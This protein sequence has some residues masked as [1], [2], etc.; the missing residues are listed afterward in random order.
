MQAKVLLCDYA[1]VAQNKL[2]ITG[3]NI[4]RLGVQPSEPPYG[5]NIALA[6]SVTIPWNATNQQHV[7][8]IELVSDQGGGTS[9]RVPLSGMLPPNHDPADNGMIVAA[10]NAGRAPDMTPGEDTLIP[11]AIPIFGLPLPHPGSYFFNIR[12]DG[13]DVDRVSFRVD[14]MNPG[15]MQ[16]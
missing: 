14:I 8:T 7:M 9:E 3:A 6:I 12:I 1:E 4:N 11:I 16:L 15:F 10:F 5:V 13:T 2:F